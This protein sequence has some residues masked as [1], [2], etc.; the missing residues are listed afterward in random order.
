MTHII[1]VFVIIPPRVLLLDVAGP[2]EVLRKANMEQSIV[3]FDVSYI[4]PST[5]VASSIGLT[6]AGMAPLPEA[7]PDNALVVISGNS[8]MPLREPLG[9]PLSDL[10]LIHI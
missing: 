8:D 5:A 1:P 2:M 6:I 3:R 9:G 10:S 4:G 7:L